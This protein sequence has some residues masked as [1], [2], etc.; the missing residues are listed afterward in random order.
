MET[1]QVLGIDVG[2]S[3][4]KG[5]IVDVY[6]GELLTERL[7]VETPQPSK[8]KA[9][10]KAIKGLCKMHKWEKGLIGVGFPAVVIK[11]EARTAANIS[12]D[13]IGTSI[14]E[15][16]SEATGCPVIAVNDAD[17]AG[18]AEMEFGAGKGVLGTV[19]LITIGSGLGSAVF[20]DGKI[21]RNTEF[22]HLMMNG[23]IA[24]H[25]ASDRTRQEEDLSW[26]KWGK[27]FNEYL[28]YLERIVS[29]NL[30]ILGG[31]ASKK[32]DEYKGQ[33]DV[34]FPI[35]T[36]QFRNKAGAIGAALYAYQEWREGQLK[37]DNW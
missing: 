23:M 12:K 24:E 15:V 3:G 14:E 30:L 34:S 11:G 9:I 17:A 33:L 32:Y 26:K 21:V 18:I 16:V 6:T 19:V 31:G 20:T 8:P 25:Y 2:A 37:G 10:A 4:I 7:R 13:W 22:G 29:P 28:N 5:G 27:R 1:N 36:A 35:E